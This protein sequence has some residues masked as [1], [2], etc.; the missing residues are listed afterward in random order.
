MKTEWGAVLKRGCSDKEVCIEEEGVWG[1]RLYPAT[2]EDCDRV[3]TRLFVT[4]RFSPS[5]F[6]SGGVVLT[7]CPVL[8]EEFVS[9]LKALKARFSVSR[10]DI[11]EW[12][13][14]ITGK[15]VETTEKTG[16]VE[17]LETVYVIEEPEDLGIWTVHVEH[18]G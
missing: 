15:R 14:K 6:G 4:D 11:A 18:R 16:T 7:L 10:E 13:S 9:D 5:M 3:W 17:P 12:L 8:L 2:R 1:L